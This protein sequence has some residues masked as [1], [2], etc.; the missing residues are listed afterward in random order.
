MGESTNNLTVMY[1]GVGI[2]LLHFAILDPALAIHMPE[3]SRN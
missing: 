1:E 2:F 3:W